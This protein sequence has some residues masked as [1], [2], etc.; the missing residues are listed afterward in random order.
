[1][2]FRSFLQENMGKFGNMFFPS[3][4]LTV[5]AIFGENFAKK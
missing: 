3:V 5:L 2:N 4:F 1:M